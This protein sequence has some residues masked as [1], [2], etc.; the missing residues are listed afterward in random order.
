MGSHGDSKMSSS[1][2]KNPDAV[3]WVE[4]VVEIMRLIGTRQLWILLDVHDTE[5]GPQHLSFAPC[6]VHTSTYR[7]LIDNIIAAS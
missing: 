5:T 3:L 4:T 6:P 7:F 2:A 1:G